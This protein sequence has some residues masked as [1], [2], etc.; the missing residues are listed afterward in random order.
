MAHLTVRS[1]YKKLEE[2][3]NLFPQGAPP[4]ESLYKIL[5]VLFHE[6]EANLVSQLPI[7]PFTVKKAASIWK[8]SEAEAQ[9]ILNDLASRALLLDIVQGEEQQY[10][11]PPPMAGFFE[12]AFMRSR[13]DL[14]QKL[15]SE[16]FHQYINVEED[17]IKDLFLG[18]E[19]RL[20]RVFVQEAV[21]TNDN[22]LHILDYERASYIIKSA[23]TIAVGLCY[24]RHK[25]EHLG[26]NCSAP[27]SNCMTFGNTASSLIKHGHARAISPSEGL[28][29]LQEAYEHNLVQCGENVREEVSFLCNCCGCCCEGLIAVRKFGML[30]PIHT[31]NYLPKIN[32]KECNG[33]GRCAKVC[34][35]EAIQMTSQSLDER[36][37][38]KIDESICL[39]CAVCIRCCPTKCLILKERPQRIITPVNSVH[40]IVL[41]A[42]ERG[43]LQNLIFDN[44]ALQS[45]RSMA[46]ILSVILQLPPM[47][48]LMAS[49]ELRSRYLERLLSKS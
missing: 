24:C 27:M 6:N 35:I 29:L 16:L 48:Q 36:K 18:S 11:L 41:S 45:H 1:G 21:L 26:K 14:D 25:M 10:V 34:P 38:A 42:I 19:T 31:T 32:E 40:R 28:A 20:G 49:K 44:Q 37:K 30:Q 22:A 5:A 33:C 8:K 23:T 17:F 15:L 43:K 4:S 3:L 12:F 13:G 2:R 46:A 39:G 7:R 47:K 9:K